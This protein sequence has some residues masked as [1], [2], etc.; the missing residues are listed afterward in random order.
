LLP[1]VKVQNG[2]CIEDDVE[3]VYIFHT[4]FSKMI[5]LSIFQMFLFTW[6]KNK[7]LWKNS[8]LENSKWRK[9]LI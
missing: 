7:I 9:N 4:R 5:F 8:F 1:G 2:G 6:D 3:N